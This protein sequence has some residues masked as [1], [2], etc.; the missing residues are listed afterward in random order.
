MRGERRCHELDDAAG[1][2]LAVFQQG[3]RRVHHRN[4][5]LQLAFHAEDD[6]VGDNQLIFAGFQHAGQLQR[7][8]VEAERTVCAEDGAV[9]TAADHDLAGEDDLLEHILVGNALC[10]NET[11]AEFLGE[12]ANH[13][14]HAGT[15]GVTGG[16]IMV[17][18]HQHLIGV[19]NALCLHRGQIGNAVIYHDVIGLQC[20]NAAGGCG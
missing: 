18:E 5:V 12:I 4:A 11:A 20:D 2:A 13:A 3:E 7:A 15:L 19:G 9:A 10:L 16:N 6:R 14:E 8:D 1:D 17:K